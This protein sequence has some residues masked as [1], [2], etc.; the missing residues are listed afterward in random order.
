MNPSHRQV[1]ALTCST[2]WV[3]GVAEMF[4]AVGLDVPA[5]FAEAGMDIAMLND[6]HAS[7][8][9]EKLCALWKVAALRSNN[10]AIG[11]SVPEVTTPA[12][13]DVVG[14]AMMSSENLYASLERL[15]C[16]L[17]LVTDAAT[18][19][20]TEADGGYWFTLAINGD[21]QKNVPRQRFDF[22]LITLVTFCRWVTK[23]DIR[24]LAV[25]FTHPEPVDRAP[26]EDAFRCP[27]RFGAA[28]N[29][30]FLSKTDISTPLPSSNPSLASLHDRYASERLGRLDQHRIRAKTQ[31]LIMRRLAHGEPLRADIASAL[32]ISERTLQRRLQDE[33]T[34]FQELVERTRYSL[35]QQYLGQ[36]QLP[37]SETVFL[38]GF[39]D[40]S[41]LFRA[42]KRWFNMSPKQY[43]DHLLLSR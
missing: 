30:I 37:I 9:T 28:A 3:K 17:R 14:Y 16:Y 33:G 40:Q 43:R 25:E 20:L 5:L 23:Q 39:T 26:Y 6:P 36:D 7:Y 42:C 13:F 8:P 11:L 15:I 31:D 27:L 2:T 21:M 1:S 41:A 18:I 22:N 10:P 4:K 34:S 19:E 24:P 35:A 32:C 29:R 38:L 12:I